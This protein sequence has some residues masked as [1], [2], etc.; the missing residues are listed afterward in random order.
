MNTHIIRTEAGLYGLRRYPQVAVTT[1]CTGRVWLSLHLYE[2]K[3][4]YICLLLLLL[5]SH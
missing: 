2:S 4:V 1:F 3:Q 5:F